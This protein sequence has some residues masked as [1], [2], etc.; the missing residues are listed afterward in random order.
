M[1]KFEY[2]SFNVKLTNSDL[3]LLGSEGWELVTHTA[4]T[5]YGE[6]GQYYVFKRP[7]ND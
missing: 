5:A 4:V 1:Q 7:L 2:Y 3:N 6:L